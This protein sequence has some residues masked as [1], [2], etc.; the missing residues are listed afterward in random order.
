[1]TGR[2]WLSGVPPGDFYFLSQGHLHPRRSVLVYGFAHPTLSGK[3]VLGFLFISGAL[4]SPD[5]CLLL[6]GKG[7]APLTGHGEGLGAAGQGADSVS[8]AQA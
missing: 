4:T 8:R 6:T 1:M 5:G 7:E 3:S 2:Q